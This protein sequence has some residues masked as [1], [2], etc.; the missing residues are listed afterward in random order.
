MGKSSLGHGGADE[1]VQG[2]GVELLDVKVE[3]T[4]AVEHAGRLVGDFL[5][6]RQKTWSFVA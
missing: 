1:C 5:A 4:T 2:L 6:R 3:G